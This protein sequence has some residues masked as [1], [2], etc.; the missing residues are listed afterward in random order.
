MAI[1]HSMGRTVG[2]L[3]EAR[4]ADRETWVEIDPY[5]GNLLYAAYKHGIKS[6]RAQR[7]LHIALEEFLDARW[8]EMMDEIEESSPIVYAM[9]TGDAGNG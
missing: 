5:Y 6:D 9:V 4:M 8:G 7:E 2:E 3:F 1:T